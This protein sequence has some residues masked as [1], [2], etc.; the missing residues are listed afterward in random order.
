MYILQILCRGGLMSSKTEDGAKKGK[1]A[2]R[3]NRGTNGAPKK[4]SGEHRKSNQG[5]NGRSKG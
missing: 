4:S 2:D 5:G 3:E 1:S